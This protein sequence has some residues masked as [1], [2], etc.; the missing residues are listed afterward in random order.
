M[1]ILSLFSAA[2]ALSATVA[3]HAQT[4]DEILAEIDT[5]SRITA[6]SKRAL[7]KC[8]NSPAA[9]ALK[10]RAIARRAAK[11]DA[12]RKKRGIKTSKIFLLAYSWM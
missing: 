4:P 1:T 3:A 9:L 7:D 5:R 8:A 6:H 10:E 2:L 11:A 12:L